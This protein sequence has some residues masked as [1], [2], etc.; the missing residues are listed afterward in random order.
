MAKIWK[1]A[2]GEHAIEWEMCRERHCIALGWRKLRDYRRFGKS[3]ESVVRALGGG[4]GNG[5]GAATS[6]LRFTHAVKP[7]D[8]VVANRGRSQVVGIGVVEGEYIPASSRTNPSKSKMLPHARAVDWLI[9]RPVDLGTK[10]F[11]PSTVTLLSHDRFNQICR[12]Y[13]NRYPELTR[14]LRNLCDRA[15]I[16]DQGQVDTREIL[17]LT[18]HQ[19]EEDGVFDPTNIRDARTRVL[20]MIVQRQGQSVF[21]RRLLAAYR[22]RCAISGCSIEELLEAAHIVPYRGKETNRS[23]NGMLLRA[24]LHTLFDLHLIS[25]NPLNMRVLVSSKL[26]GSDYEQYRGK[27]LRVPKQ[28][29]SRPSVAALNCH[30]GMYERGG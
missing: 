12:A 17:R 15:F 14:V 24:D 26:N 22:R 3:R 23:G 29:S 9:E 19:L 7:A 4:P 10:F 13:R 18:K 6:I 21:R 30:S 16:D 5:H 11:A 27:K 2:P 25:I 28:S 20:S 8:L 1:I